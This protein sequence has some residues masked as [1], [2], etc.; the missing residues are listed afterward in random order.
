VTRGVPAALLA[1]AL[2]AACAPRP[3]IDARPEELAVGG[4]WV[5]VVHGP[6][7]ASAARDVRGAIARAAP[8]VLR[9]GGLRVPVT[10]TIHPSHAALERATARPG[11]AW[12]RA[13]AR[14]DTVEL[15]SPRTW[16]FFA[17]S[18]RKL[19]EL[20]AHELTHCAM[21]QRA[22]DAQSWMF[23]EIPPWFSEGIASV[24]AGQGHRYQG[25]DALHAVYTERP[26]RDP[27]LNPEPLYA[28]RADV[29]YGAAHHAAEFLIARY[30]E[31]RVP[32]ILGLMSNGLGF[33]AAFEAAVGLTDAE[34]AA[35]FRSQVLRGGSR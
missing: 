16:G 12:L 4:A 6:E 31:E 22:A 15:Q 8:R 29:V 5:R 25:L 7:D 9:W 28:D 21:Y 13:W 2:L 34:F 35:E 23:K 1:T 26:A 18:A 33:P 10:I 24:A 19:E 30:G 32:E 17:P 20:V 11:Q 3:A 14:F 27:L